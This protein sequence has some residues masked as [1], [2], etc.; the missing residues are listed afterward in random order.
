V[1]CKTSCTGNSDCADGTLCTSGRCATICT[2]DES[3]YASDSSD[4]PNACVYGP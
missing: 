3:N 1:S 2:Y 4:D